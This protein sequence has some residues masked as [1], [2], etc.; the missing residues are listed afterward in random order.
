MDNYR[1]VFFKV[2]G[3]SLAFI[4]ISSCTHSRITSDN[5]PGVVQSGTIRAKDISEASGLAASNHSPGV[6]WINN[7]S[8]NPAS[9]FAINAQGDKLAEIRVSGEVNT[10]WEDLA[11]FRHNGKSYIAIGDVGD[12]DSN[13]RLVS[14]IF[15]EE[16]PVKANK[17][18]QIFVVKP[19]WKVNF[20]YEDGP[21]DVE[22]VAIDTNRGKILL[23]SKRDE[24]PVLYELP[25]VFSSNDKP[26]IAKRLGE[27]KPLPKPH[28]AYFRLLDVL[29]LTEW[30]TGMD[31]SPDGKYLAVLTYGDAYLYTKPDNSDWLNVMEKSPTV[32]PLPE[33]K[34][35][36]AIGF[37][38]ID[39]HLYITTEKLPAPVICVDIHKFRSENM[40]LTNQ[41]KKESSL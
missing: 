25:L 41:E 28:E 4:W 10:D 27:I 3:I 13:R 6:F 31:I 18:N 29:G 32:I 33:L 21:R 5:S 14:L 34:Q 38:K 26:I 11:T 35:G 36:E 15:I 19:V 17:T 2:I 16:P 1:Q 24:V 9:L 23:L 37:D 40:L 8:W 30:P 39:Q 12:N 22:S 20:Q 7:D